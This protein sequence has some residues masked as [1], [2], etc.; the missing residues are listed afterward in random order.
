MS[1]SRAVV[2]IDL[3]VA[4]QDVVFRQFKMHRCRLTHVMS[5]YER[6]QHALEQT[7]AGME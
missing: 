3:G 4:Q 2:I 6:I 1:A 7:G 5:S